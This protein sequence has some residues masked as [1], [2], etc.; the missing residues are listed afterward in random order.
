M[1]P[2]LN[3]YHPQ[4]ALP[5]GT[6]ASSAANRAKARHGIAFNA[7][8]IS[9]QNSNGLHPWDLHLRSTTDPEVR[10]KFME[11]TLKDLHDAVS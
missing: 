3:S 5:G 8:E 4:F 7:P 1:S 10:K 11:D 6:I 2:Q 9:S